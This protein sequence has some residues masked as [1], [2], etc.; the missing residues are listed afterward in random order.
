MAND[1]QMLSTCPVAGYTINRTVQHNAL[2]LTFQYL[3][4]PQQKPEEANVS[5][6]FVMTHAQAVELAQK[7]LR[8]SRTI[9]GQEPVQSNPDSSL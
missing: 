6:N 2:V 4:S 7:I 9:P 5:P 1:P 8:S 3:T